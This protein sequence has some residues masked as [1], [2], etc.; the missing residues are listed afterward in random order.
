MVLHQFDAFESGTKESY[1]KYC[2]RINWEQILKT[3]YENGVMLSMSG[4]DRNWNEKMFEEMRQAFNKKFNREPKQ[5]KEDI[6][7]L[8]D[9]YLKKVDAKIAPDLQKYQGIINTVKTCLVVQNLMKSEGYN[10]MALNY[11]IWVTMRYNYDV[12]QLRAGVK[13][14]K[15]E[16]F[17]DC[18]N[19][20]YITTLYNY[21]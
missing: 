4:I 19:A 7:W 1:E 16:K 2:R 15:M 9:Y 12:S 5:T 6:S 8:T 18:I 20:Y 3:F 14:E 17:A 13:D 11:A 21:K 10:A